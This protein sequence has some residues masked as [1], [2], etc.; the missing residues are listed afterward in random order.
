MKAKC[1]LCS[2]SHGAFLQ[3]LLQELH[4][5]SNAALGRAS[6][7]DILLHAAPVVPE[8]GYVCSKQRATDGTSAGGKK[9]KAHWGN[10]ENVVGEIPKGR[11]DHLMAR[12][13]SSVSLFRATFFDSAAKTA[14]PEIPWASLKG[15]WN[16]QTDQE[17]CL[18][19]ASVC[20]YT[21]FLFQ[22]QKDTEKERIK[23]RRY[24]RPSSRGS[25]PGQWPAC[26]D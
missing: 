3:P 26:Q 18:L 4:L 10:Q 9:G 20:I 8:R 21:Y 14:L 22:N 7:S 17:R 25:R 6:R 2:N 16:T 15:T 23:L 5:C 24:S 11:S 19:D 12:R 1:K 13:S